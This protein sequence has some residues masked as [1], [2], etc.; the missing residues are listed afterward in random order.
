MFKILLQEVSI[1]GQVREI[2]QGIFQPLFARL[3]PHIRQL[4]E[5]EEQFNTDLSDIEMMYI[6]IGLLFSYFVQ[7]VVL[8]FPSE[9]EEK[10]LELLADQLLKLL[11]K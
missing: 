1:N 6:F 4:G 5:V 11:Q 9:D 7:R 2:A 8:D 10:D 3:I